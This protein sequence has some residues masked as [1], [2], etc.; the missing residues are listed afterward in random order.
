MANK[1]TAQ[2]YES[3][4][5]VESLR[6]HPENPRR[7][8]VEAIEESINSTG[9]YGTV[10]A[11]EGTRYILAGNHRVQAAR[12]AGLA[13]VPVM[14]VECDTQTARRILL[15]DNRTND[16]ATYDEEALRTLLETLA[17]EAEESVALALA[18]TGFDEGALDDLIAKLDPP[19]LD[20]L[21]EEYGDEPEEGSFWPVIRVK[22][23]PEV[24]DQ[25]TALLSATPGEEEAVQFANLLAE[26]V[27]YRAGST[28][29]TRSAPPTAPVSATREPPTLDDLLAGASDWEPE[30]SEE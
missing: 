8:N 3:A 18:G 14:W 4:V 5:P 28:G 20:E 26:V 15:A 17:E 11:Q 27:A 29:Q 12:K 25:Y 19:T 10:V 2:H 23:P 1:I 6:Q 30:E 7:G 22:V 24:R 13:T 21:E 9:F 16:L